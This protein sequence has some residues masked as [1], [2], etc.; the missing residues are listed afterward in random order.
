M[1]VPAWLGSGEM[2]HPS[3][4]VAA[5]SLCPHTAF[6]QCVHVEGEWAPVSPLLFFWGG[7]GWYN[8]M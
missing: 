5:F 3:L 8:D 4:Q 7:G 6:P 1:G 2:A